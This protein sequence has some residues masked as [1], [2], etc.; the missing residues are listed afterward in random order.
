MK[1]LVVKAT[2]DSTRLSLEIQHIN[3]GSSPEIMPVGSP[4]LI[5]T[6]CESRKTLMR[7][8]SAL[9]ISEKTIREAGRLAKLRESDVQR[10]IDIIDDSDI[11]LQKLMI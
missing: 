6:M 7:C 2:E 11:N 3:N 8:A 1:N 4:T 5:N 10:L 9:T